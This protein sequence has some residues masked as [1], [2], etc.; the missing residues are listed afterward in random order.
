MCCLLD[1]KNLNLH[2]LHLIWTVISWQ[3]GRLHAVLLCLSLE[4]KCKNYSVN[5]SF[6][7][8]QENSEIHFLKELIK[9]FGCG[10]VYFN[11]NGVSSYYVNNKNDLINKIIP[12][13]EKNELQTI[14]QQS[15]LRFNIFYFLRTYPYGVSQHKY[16]FFHFICFHPQLH[17]TLERR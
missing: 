11:K 10:Q 16:Y 5:F 6:S 12:F 7:I 15:Y 3:F 14:K 1:S 13:F 4:K 9:F 17:M 8:G 2:Q